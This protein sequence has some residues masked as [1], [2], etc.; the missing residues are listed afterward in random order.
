MAVVV[1]VDV[2]AEVASTAVESSTN[3]RLSL[4]SQGSVISGRKRRKR[5]GR[6]DNRTVVHF[7]AVI[8]HPRRENF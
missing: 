6:R 2:P 8:R 1:T 4:L 7:K 3:S 5:E